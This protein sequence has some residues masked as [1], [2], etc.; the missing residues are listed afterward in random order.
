MRFDETSGFFPNIAFGCAVNNTKINFGNETTNKIAGVFGL[1]IGPRSMITQLQTQIKGKFTYCLGPANKTATMYFG[2]DAHIGG[3]EHIQRIAM[4]PEARYHL[5]L[6]GITV[7]DERLILEPSLF[8][9]DDQNYTT[10]FFIDLSTPYTVLSNTA[11]TK[12]KE[13]IVQHFSELQMEPLPKNKTTGI[14]D[15]C[16]QNPFKSNSTNTTRGTN[17]TPTTF[18]INAANATI[19]ANSTDATIGANS[20]DTTIGAN[21][22]DTTFVPNYPSMALSFVKS[23]GDGGEVNLVLNPENLFSNFVNGNTTGFCFQMLPTPDLKDGPSIL[24][25]YQQRNFQFLFDVNARSLSF[26]PKTC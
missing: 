11:Y 13:K 26:V 23:G 17:S 21:S 6:S 16:Y 1:G 9:L 2:D 12:V 7:K 4:V 18:G 25:A 22:T 14:F 24:G 19:G 10:G 5:K 3:S 20:T 8:N 15:L